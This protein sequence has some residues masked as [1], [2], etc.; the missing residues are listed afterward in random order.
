[1]TTTPTGI[2][3]IECETC[4]KT[5]PVGREHCAQCGTGSAFINPETVL[6]L[7]C[8]HAKNGHAHHAM[9]ANPAALPCHHEDGCAAF[10]PSS[11][12]LPDERTGP[13]HLNPYQPNFWEI[14][15]HVIGG[16]E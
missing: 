9:V 13:G 10:V 8:G 1:M 14:D 3:I 6:C 15:N 7:N 12:S 2:P 11:E 4:G 16:A 5:H